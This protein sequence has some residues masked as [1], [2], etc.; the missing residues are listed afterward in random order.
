MVLPHRVSGNRLGCHRMAWYPKK[1]FTWVPFQRIHGRM[2]SSVK[3]LDNKCRDL[4]EQE[5]CK[6]LFLLM[7]NFWDEIKKINFDL[8]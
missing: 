3:N 6:K 7:G 4:L 8:K 2:I 5:H 1:V